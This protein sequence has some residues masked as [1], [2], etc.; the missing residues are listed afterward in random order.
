MLNSP[1]RVFLQ[2][3][4]Q[5]SKCVDPTFIQKF[6][7]TYPFLGSESRL[8]VDIG[9]YMNIDLLV[10]YIEITTNYDSFALCFEFLAIILKGNLIFINF[11]WQ[12]FEL[13]VTCAWNIYNHKIKHLVLKSQHSSLLTVLWLL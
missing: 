1:P 8:L 10:T 4:I 6:F 5:F 9:S 7:E 12:S 2:I 13:F 11:V 3:R